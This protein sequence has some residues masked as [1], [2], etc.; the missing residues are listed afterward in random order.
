MTD[1][2]LFTPL[3][4][5][6]FDVDEEETDRAATEV[7]DDA[8]LRLLKRENR[9]AIARAP[10]RRVS[11]PGQAADRCGHDVPLMFALHAHPE[12][13]FAWSRFLVDLS[14]TPDCVIADMAPREVE[15]LPVEVETTVGLDLSFSVAASV[16]DLSGAPQVGRRRTVYHPMVLASGVGF[17]K[18]YWD[19]YPKAGDYL[20]SDK[21]LRLL[22]DAPAGTPVHAAFTV[23]VKVRFRGLPRLI[24]LLA[25]TST[26]ERTVRLA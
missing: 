16:V 3:T 17:R 21:E 22:V 14:P 23:R 2:T 1:D 13:T 19:F 9:V 18:A 24:P 26:T 11:A 5:L 6:A 20:H 15:D 10:S 4:E 8:T 25:R 12:C 7:I